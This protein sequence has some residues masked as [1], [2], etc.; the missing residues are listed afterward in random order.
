MVNKHHPVVDLC[1]PPSVAGR[2][3]DGI[4]K[5]DAGGT[6]GQVDDTPGGKGKRLRAAGHLQV[7]GSRLPSPADA[8]VF[9]AQLADPGQALVQLIVAIQ[10]FLVLPVWAATPYSACSS[11]LRVRSAPQRGCPVADDGGVQ[12]LVAVGLGGGD[13]T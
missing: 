10:P 3:S 8:L 7:G 5:I 13:I 9:P 6:R 11:I 4:G 12:A 1:S 2:R